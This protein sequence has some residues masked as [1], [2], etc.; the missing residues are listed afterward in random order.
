[1]RDYFP[2]VSQRVQNQKG[3]LFLLD[4]EPRQNSKVAH[5]AMERVAC[6]LFDF[7][8][9]SPEINPIENMFHLIRRQLIEDVQK[10]DI[11]KETYEQFSNL[12]KN[13]IQNFPVSAVIKTIES[14]NKRMWFRHCD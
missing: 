1:M 2:S 4:I 7:L 6:R 12:V 8:P 9:R 11:T 13:T 5:K 14:M 3:R 10:Y